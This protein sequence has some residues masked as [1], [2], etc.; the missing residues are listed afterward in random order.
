MQNQY[1]LKYGVE[2]EL[3]I[4][5]SLQR[6]I[7]A[8]AG[9]RKGKQFPQLKTTIRQID[10]TH[11]SALDAIPLKRI[12]DRIMQTT[13]LRLKNDTFEYASLFSGALVSG[14]I[15]LGCPSDILSGVE[16]D[17]FRVLE[18]IL[19]LS[20]L[21]ED[22]TKPLSKL[23]YF[24]LRSSIKDNVVLNALNYVSMFSDYIFADELKA[25]RAFLEVYKDAKRSDI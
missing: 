1:Q 12:L 2:W 15:Y 6:H 11:C 5:N 16:A 8:S 22:S 3:F 7:L 14:E 18:L 21:N 13:A 19:F 4:E 25:V 23:N 20:A 9:M 24:G 17:Y 10:D